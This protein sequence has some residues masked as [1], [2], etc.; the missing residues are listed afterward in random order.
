MVPPG[1]DTGR[2]PTPSGPGRE[3]DGEGRPGQ[4]AVRV[5]VVAAA[6]VMALPA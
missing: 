2:S 5:T 4:R 6:V 1:T 3:P